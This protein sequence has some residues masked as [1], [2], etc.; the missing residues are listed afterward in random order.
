MGKRA[1]PKPK[2]IGAK[3]LAVRKAHDLTQQ[4]LGDILKAK[5]ARISEFE[6]GKRLPNLLLLVA[7]AR[8]GGIPMEFL[9][10]DEIDLDY[11]TQYVG[12]RF[13]GETTTPITLYWRK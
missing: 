9:V 11:F 3:L 12:A 1:V 10:I 6:R 2:H 5:T 7:Y 13:R 8:L 4:Q